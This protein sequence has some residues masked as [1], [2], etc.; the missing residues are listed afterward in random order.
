MFLTKTRSRYNS[1]ADLSIEAVCQMS[2]D[3][4]VR[5]TE[6]PNPSQAGFLQYLRLGLRVLLSFLAAY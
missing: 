3:I 4:P 2:F 6:E 5:A 1:N